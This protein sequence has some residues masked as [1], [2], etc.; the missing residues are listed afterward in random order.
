MN[1]TDTFVL[2]LGG[3]V[4]DV[5]GAFG[6]AF[7]ALARG[8]AHIEA[9]S[10]V[11]RTPPWGK[12]DQPDFLNMA[13]AGRTDLS[14]RALLDLVLAVERGEG[15][16]RIER[17]GPRTLDIDIILFGDRIVD[18]PDLRV[19]HPRVTERAFVLAPLAEILPDGVVAGRP[20]SAWVREVDASGMLKDEA[21][22]ARVGDA[23]RALRSAAG[24]DRFTS[25]D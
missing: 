23:F 20:V 24:K 13:A 3:N 5:A 4:G 2:S 12:T 25:S 11:W 16:E 17:W 8:G 22:T 19:P 10:S 7:G 14:P 6:R 21:A 9:I 1:P 15:R 18:E